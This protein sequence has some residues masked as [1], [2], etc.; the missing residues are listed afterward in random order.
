MLDTGRLSVVR[1]GIADAGLASKPQRI[2]TNGLGS[3]VGVVIYDERSGICGLDHVMLPHA[4]K[5]K[6]VTPAKFADTGLPWLVEKLLESGAERRHLQA[7]LAGG[8]QMFS[9]ASGSA[10]L[11]IGPRNVEAVLESLQE[12]KVP[13]VSQDVGGSA[14]RTIEFDPAT[15]VLHVHTALE[16]TCEI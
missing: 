14:G 12:L 9:S 8:A 4:P 16:G 6:P 11:R 10:L 7:K 15:S 13:V 5:G 3:C 1:I 2:R